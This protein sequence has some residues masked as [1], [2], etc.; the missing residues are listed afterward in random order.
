MA[1]YPQIGLRVDEDLLKRLD[2]WRREQ[3]DLPARP[4]AVR[5]LIEKGL[6]SIPE[7]S[8]QAP[9]VKG[10]RSLSALLLDLYRT[11]PDLTTW[12]FEKGTTPEQALQ[13]D[14][15]SLEARKA[16]RK[17]AQQSDFE[18]LRSAAELILDMLDNDNLPNDPARQALIDLVR[19]LTE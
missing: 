6:T 2:N 7:Q 16:R 10:S 1:E 12:G 11:A 3:A 13:F 17:S 8:A 5:R 18:R 4:E 14:L 19:P 9:S 15:P